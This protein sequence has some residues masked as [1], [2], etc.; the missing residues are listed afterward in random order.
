MSKPNSHPEP[1]APLEYSGGFQVIEISSST[2]KHIKVF[3]NG[4][5]ALFHLGLN[6]RGGQA[7]WVAVHLFVLSNVLKMP[8]TSY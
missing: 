4:S 2:N 8:T 3:K 5:R 6:I 1:C 7:F